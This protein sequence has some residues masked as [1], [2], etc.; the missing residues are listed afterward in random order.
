MEYLVLNSDVFLWHS[1]RQYMVYNSA[2]GKQCIG[3][4][5]PELISAIES[6]DDLS[7]LYN[8]CL[9]NLWNKKPIGCFVEDVLSIDAGTLFEC[10]DDS[11]CPVT[12]KPVLKVQNDL[13]YVAKTRDVNT[14]I[15]SIQ[16]IA[17]HMGGETRIPE[18]L[19]GIHGQTLFPIHGSDCV[20]VDAL[21][22][23][24]DAFPKGDH[25]EVHVLEYSGKHDD[26]LLWLKKRNSQ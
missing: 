13:S 11:Q 15:E 17:I 9:P 25:L 22:A 8:I 21:K 3:N 6:L 1:D 10:K 7:R 14:V 16:S 26:F 18:R 19:R 2:N 12:L 4:L 24:L 23:M 20:D 5:T